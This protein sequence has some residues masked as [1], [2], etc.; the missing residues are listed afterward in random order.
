MRKIINWI[1]NIDIAYIC[2]IAVYCAGIVT[3]LL[4]GLLMID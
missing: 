3:G 4:V 1:A 2:A